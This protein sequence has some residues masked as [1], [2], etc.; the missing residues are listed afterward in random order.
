MKQYAISQ[1]EL[2]GRIDN[3]EK[4]FKNYAIDNNQNIEEMQRAIN[5]LLDITKPTKIGF[6]TK[7]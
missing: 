1:N 5:Y 2:S 7:K 4:A 3:L 6:N